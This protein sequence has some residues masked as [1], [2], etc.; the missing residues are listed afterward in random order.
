MTLSPA[1]ELALYAY[2]YGQGNL[3]RHLE[4]YGSVNINKLPT[5]TREYVEKIKE[6]MAAGMDLTDAQ[7]EVESSNRPTVISNQ[8]A[9]GLM[10]VRPDT[11]RDPGFTDP[12]DIN[13]S[14]NLANLRK[15]FTGRSE[16][17]VVELLKDPDINKNF[18]IAYR[19]ALTQKYTKR[20]SEENRLAM[21]D[22][23][24]KPKPFDPF[25][26][27][28]E[29][30]IIKK[31]QIEFD[32]FEEVEEDSDQ[33]EEV[34]D[35]F[36]NTSESY[37]KEENNFAHISTNRRIQFGAARERMVLGMLWD[38]GRGTVRSLFNKNKTYAEAMDEIN[39][40]ELE[41]IYEEFPEF[42]GVSFYDEDA[43]MLAGRLGVAFVD[44]VSYMLPWTKAARMGYL[45]TMG[46]SGTYAAALQAG[47]GHLERDETMYSPTTLGGTF[48]VG[49]ALGGVGLSAT[50]FYNKIKAN[51]VGT[52][53]E[54]LDTSKII[55]DGLDE[56]QQTLE[57]IKQTSGNPS[58]K[59]VNE[60]AEAPQITILKNNQINRDAWTGVPLN[61]S[62]TELANASRQSFN[63]RSTPEI[64]RSDLNYINETTERI[65]NASGSKL[66]PD[67]KVATELSSDLQIIIRQSE[68]LKKITRELQ[69]IKGSNSKKNK[70]KRADLK[71]LKIQL[72]ESLAATR[73]RDLKNTVDRSLDGQDLA[74]LTFDTAIKE[75]RLTHGIMQGLIREGTRPVFGALGGFTASQFF[76]DTEDGYGSTLAWTVG[77]AALMRWQ[78]KIQQAKISEFD[79]ETGEMIIHDQWRKWMS[80]ANLK[81]VTASSISTKL[82]SLGGVGKVI[83]NLLFDR[84]GGATK[85][86][87]SMA[88]EAMV[89]WSSN[90]QRTLGESRSDENVML[91]VGEAM[92]KFITGASRTDT[93]EQVLSKITAGYKGLN[94][95]Q[96]Q[97]VKRIV[98][99]LEK[100]RDDLALSVERIGIPFERLDDYG[101]AQL[102]NLKE[103]R[104]NPEKFKKILF[105]NLPQL[106][107]GNPAT[108]KRRLDR[109][110]GRMFPR[111][112]GQ[113]DMRIN[114]ARDNIVSPD[115]K[116]RP[117]MNHFE[118]ERY[119][120]D[121][122]TRRL[123]AQEGFINLNAKDVLQTYARKTIEIREFAK[124]FGP[125]S[126]RLKEAFRIIDNSFF[127]AGFSKS[128][129]QY[130]KY[131]NYVRDSI[132]AY[133]GKYG[134]YATPNL[135]GIVTPLSQSMVALANMRYLTRVALPSLGDFIQPFKATSVKAAT[136]A[137]GYRFSGAESAP[138]RRVGL[139]YNDDF[140][141]ELRAIL[142]G[143][144]DALSGFTDFINREQ[145]R[146]FKLVQLKRITEQAGRFAFDAGAFRAFDV[147][148]TLSK[149]KKI[150][151]PLQREIK[152]M[153]LQN[154]DLFYLAK[155]KNANEAF[156]DTI[157]KQILTRAGMKVMDRD[158]LVPKVGN[159]L[160]FTQHRDPV[161]RQLGQF[162]SW[163]QAKTA[164]TNAMV[165]RIED[166]DVALFMRIV[167]ANVIAGGAINFLRTITSPNYNEEE[168]L[169]PLQ[170]AQKSL[171]MGGDFNNWFFS[172]AGSAIKYNLN[173][174][175]SLA[176]AASPSWAWGA[177]AIE[178]TQS[179]FNNLVEDGD[180][181]GSL[182]DIVNI[183]PYIGEVN[184]QLE[185]FDLPHLE[186]K[187]K[188]AKPARS[189]FTYAKGG[190]V[191]EV[192]NVPSEPDERIDKMTGL[193]YD[194]QAGTA[195][196]DE[197]DPL[198]RLGFGLGSIVA[199]AATK[200][201]LEELATRGT[202]MPTRPIKD[203]IPDKARAERAV[204][205][206]LTQEGYHGTLSPDI[207][208]FQ[209]KNSEL[210]IHIG[211]PEQAHIRAGHVAG[212]TRPPPKRVLEDR[213]EADAMEDY[214]KAYPEMFEDYDEIAKT[215]AKEAIAKLRATDYDIEEV[216]DNANIL[217]VLAKANN[218]LRLDDVNVW[219]NVE[220]VATALLDS[221]IVKR[222]VR[223]KEVTD[224]GVVKDIE[225][226]RKRA[227]AFENK[228]RKKMRDD[229]GEFFMIDVDA[230]EKSPAYMAL[231]DE[232]KEFIKS[233]GYDSIVYLNKGEVHYGFGGHKS[234]KPTDS[235]II[236]EPKDIRLRTAEFK[237]LESDRL[238]DYDGGKVLGSL[239]KRK[240]VGGIAAR[241]GSKL[242]KEVMTPVKSVGRGD[243]T[244]IIPDPKKPVVVRAGEEISEEL[245]PRVQRAKADVEAQ[246][247]AP[248]PG[249]FSDPTHSR[250]KG[251]DFKKEL[252]DQGIEIDLDFGNY[253]VMG[254][255]EGSPK[256]VPKEDVTDKTFQNLLISA[257]ASR[258]MT[259]G[260]NKPLAKANIYDGEDLTLEQM[261]KNYRDATGEK[262]PQRVQTNLV[263]PELFKVIINNKER[264]LDYPIVTIQS[265]A[266]KMKELGFKTDHGY[267]LDVQ[268]VGP[269]RMNR[270]TSR[271]KKGKVP[272]PNLRPETVGSIEKGNIIGQIKVSGKLHDLYD[273]L[274]VDATPSLGK[275]VTVKE[276]FYRGGKIE[277]SVRYRHNQGGFFSALSNVVNKSMDYLAERVYGITGKQ[278]T[279]NFKDAFDISNEAIDRGF[280]P[281]SERSTATEILPDGSKGQ[282]FTL[283]TRPEHQVLMEAG[284]DPSKTRVGFPR[285]KTKEKHSALHNAIN[286]ALLGA[287]H[288][289]KRGIQTALNAKE[290][291]QLGF[292]RSKDYDIDIPNNNLGI[293]IGQ[294]FPDDEPNRD[295][296]IRQELLKKVQ[297]TQAAKDRGDPLM[298]GVHIFY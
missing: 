252:E 272:Q 66:V 33:P 289:N 125:N 116:L 8:N 244:K 12:N 49:A 10:Q 246:S 174:G 74:E 259:E 226:F 118:K 172:K 104:N 144:N 13:Y 138:S 122:E 87:E 223:G 213:E 100:Q 97:E 155:F 210:G 194:Q 257:R 72:E 262:N 86:V 94:E 276:K 112:T 83:G 295:F 11:A 51:K 175:D 167:G 77:G 131:K 78:K 212:E 263:Q 234:I 270:I 70:K 61:A 7:I 237:N 192:P 40:E 89:N 117:L 55:D 188:D 99:L 152:E 253:V 274:E 15:Q 56:T 219:S 288:A 221:A 22:S 209:I 260:I 59:V 225:D 164:Q 282:V 60:N 3:D 68:Q 267:A 258:K 101:M 134:S 135:G 27:I 141:D 177:S 183:L 107:K 6:R 93:T 248:V 294:K 16:E 82:D 57:T 224:Y 24:L 193:P 271:D 181:E 20:P 119:I 136:K 216:M 63:G 145:R 235:L 204:D 180:V 249:S 36:L 279:Q 185:R 256:P 42:R 290:Y 65:I 280:A 197:E 21:I 169:E 198:R 127:N 46:M 80:T 162:A 214:M 261:K 233:F 238:L 158:R 250:F 115:Y 143:S 207:E 241:M 111:N 159:R 31:P 123:L 176:E 200:I 206:G 85:S 50:R 218:P 98:P 211:T 229:E 151:S 39:V 293:A 291:A 297:E 215:E 191:F 53:I 43:V 23:A 139:K 52:E 292:T 148:K 132:N 171:E 64:S 187:R 160:L 251:E 75:G 245:D 114:Y 113:E 71:A 109:L 189:F 5:E 173:R 153:G 154:E 124:T 254:T 102:Y 108:K 269:V 184:K 278:Q 239:R 157:G 91:V 48:A 137:L 37:D 147:S 266:K 201:P 105:D 149:N 273:Y 54:K 58:V 35:P 121:F 255:K 208:A 236:F 264:R 120:K 73:L 47:M 9:V 44:P 30:E 103:I 18:G 133:F 150:T 242:F 161:V 163:A 29:P 285:I 190:E 230:M 146:F 286:H 140:E 25:A 296:K 4:E 170:F 222:Q 41:K 243:Q 168:D 84:P 17:E 287:R 227:M 67:P 32:P 166:G 79:K 220:N 195:F 196:V 268:F 284:Y 142:V 202:I 130:L 28:D 62:T 205:A 179:A 298:E 19:E 95:Q 128:D 156:D 34:F 88:S 281:E 277:S 90:L 199:R 231:R 275:D 14:E 69:K 92:N 38:V 228:F 232:L 1:E 129:D 217:P 265:S 165:K 96:V 186:D 110:Y 203:I 76:A 26:E 81:F 247:V 126:E 106:Q 178:A 283:P 45:T 2:N 240:A 182:Q